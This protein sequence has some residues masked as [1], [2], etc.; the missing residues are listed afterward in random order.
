MSRRTRGWY[1][2]VV[3]TVDPTI[4]ADEQLQSIGVIGARAEIISLPRRGQFVAVQG[5]V[6][7]APVQQSRHVFPLALLEY[8]L[9]AQ[10]LGQH[11]RK[12]HLEPA[13]DRWIF[14]V[15]EYIRTA[16]F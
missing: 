15:R 5:N 13:K 7:R 14:G 4:A 8:G 10:F 9:D 3:P 11:I 12:F 1:F 16:P 6:D 2:H